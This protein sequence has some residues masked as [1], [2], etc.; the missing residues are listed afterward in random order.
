MFSLQTVKPA[1]IATVRKL[2]KPPYLITLIMD[3]VLIL[4][5]KRMQRVMVD[6]DREFLVAS[7]T[8]SLKT[9]GEGNFYGKI[10]N[11]AKDLINGE[12][13]DLMVPYL[14]YQ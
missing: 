2:G 4:F 8:E 3:V 9:M 6:G 14:N 5:G 13:I 7:W 1:D 11:Y 10:V 12:M